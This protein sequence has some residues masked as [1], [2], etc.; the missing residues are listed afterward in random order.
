[1]MKKKKVLEKKEG[2]WKKVEMFFFPHEFLN[3]FHHP[4]SN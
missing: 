3:D 4:A 2:S 1:M